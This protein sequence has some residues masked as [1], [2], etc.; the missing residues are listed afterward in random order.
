MAD[1]LAHHRKVPGI[2]AGHGGEDLLDRRE[3]GVE[4]EKARAGGFG[5]DDHLAPPRIGVA[6]VRLQASS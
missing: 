6:R 3:G 2:A 1:R 5:D 4:I